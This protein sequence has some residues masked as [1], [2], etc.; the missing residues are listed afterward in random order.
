MNK[1]EAEF[2]QRL[3][4]AFMVEA[5]DHL[6]A[7][8]AGLLA[9]ENADSAAERGRQ[10]EIAFRHTH[11]LKG[12]AR[13]ASFPR[14]ETLCQAIEDIFASCRK[15]GLILSADDLDVLHR[16]FDLVSAE[17]ATGDA[18][19]QR[20]TWRRCLPGCRQSA[21]PGPLPRLCSRARR[22]RKSQ[23]PSRPQ[24]AATERRRP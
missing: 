6:L 3:R 7:T 13:A 2:L 20:P 1:R 8:A 23:P 4:A 9:L 15:D 21:G 5:R 12:A 18:P 24:E 22:A 10:L 17:L 16:A 14:I 11:S 19:R